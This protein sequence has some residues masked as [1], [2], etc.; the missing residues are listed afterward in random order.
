MNWIVTKPGILKLALTAGLLLVP[1]SC[2]FGALA[3]DWNQ[4]E[5]PLSLPS[6][7]GDAI[8]A[9]ITIKRSVEDVYAFYR[10]FRNIPGFLGDVVAIEQIDP[11][12]YRWTIQG[13]LGIRLT[14][15]TKV[16]EERADELI[17]YETVSSTLLRTRWVIS[18]RALRGGRETEFHETMQVPLGR[19]GRAVLALVGKFPREEV[20]SNL[21]RLKELLESG[22]VTNSSYA[23]AG[24]FAPLFRSVSPPSSKPQGHGRGWRR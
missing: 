23:V 11:V 7:D 22:R 16:T 10:D 20:S 4:P 17:R 14:W 9:S 19:F 12:T 24:K 1:T 8:D 2:G 3:R 15:T 6:W 18:F 13:P 21:R 5:R